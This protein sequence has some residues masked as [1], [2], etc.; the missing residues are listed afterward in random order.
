VTIATRSSCRVGRLRLIGLICAT[1]EAEYF[2]P[3]AGQVFPAAT[4]LPVVG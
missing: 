1:E 2:S 3:G 4:D